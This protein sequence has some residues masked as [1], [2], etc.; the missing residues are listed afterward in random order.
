[1]PRRRYALIVGL[2]VLL[3]LGVR[4]AF[5]F[6]YDD[7][8]HDRQA[9]LEP[10]SD[11]P[12]IGDSSFYYW[13]GRQIADGDGY[14]RPFELRD[15]DLRV[16]TAER[17]PLYPLTLAVP[18]ALGARS[19][20][21]AGIF[22]S[23]IGAGALVLVAALGRR[24]GGDGVS[25]LATGIAAVYPILWQPNAIL[26]SETIFVPLVTGMLLLTYA[27]RDRP[28]TWRWFGLGALAGLTALTR[29]EGLAYLVVLG[30]PLLWSAAATMRARVKPA[31]VLVAATVLV[32]APWTIRNLRTFDGFIPISNNLSVALSGANCDS[33]Y[34]GR[35]TGSYDLLCYFDDFDAALGGRPI[36]DEE[37]VMTAV[38]E[39]A[40]AYIGDH[41]DRLPVVVVVRAL[42]SWG[43]WTPGSL[44]DYDE[45]DYGLRTPLIAGYAMYYLM[46]PFAVAGIVVSRRRRVVVWPLLA[47]AI[48]VVVTSI[49]LS[50]H[51]RFRS[52]MEVPIVVLASVGMVAAGGAVQTWR[53]SHV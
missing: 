5:V 34:Y 13:V 10:G 53:R 43:L 28:T 24:V 23:L 7:V 44:L 14:V 4:L 49:A 25:L 20:V 42:R 26:L 9:E 11:P 18:A 52:G 12:M 38:G 1:M 22:S 29:G 50:G 16:D 41:L 46:L 47:P 2:L 37:A 51:T 32:I 6:A 8:L 36:R 33:V 40:R 21:A 48:T 30:I 17:P 15:Q 3:G 31:M 39:D 19:I 27:I 45:I 35:D